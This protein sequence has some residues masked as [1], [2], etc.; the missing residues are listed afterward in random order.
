MVV[1]DLYPRASMKM[2][3]RYLKMERN[4]T[5]DS[6]P[7][8]AEICATLERAIGDATPQLVDEENNP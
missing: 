6:S 7:L 1:V 4:R 3:L 2:A 5:G 8:F